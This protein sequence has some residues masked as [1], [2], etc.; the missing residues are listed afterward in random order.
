MILLDLAII[1]SFVVLT[2]TGYTAGLLREAIVLMAAVVGVALAGQAY[3][4]LAGDL[5]N[6]IDDEQ[7]ALLI[8]FL[9]LIGA[10]VLVGMI[11]SFVIKTT[12]TVF[13]LGSFDSLGGAFCG[14]AKALV[15]IEAVLIAFVTF[16]ALGMKDAI[17]DSVFGSLLLEQLP[18]LKA[19]LPAA[20]DA[21]IDSL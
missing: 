18:L 21:A 5:N 4:N 13:D 6:F 20:F 3:D 15:L 7:D 12:L 11:I 14:A 16:P 19:I 17:D 1:A 9:S 8:A 10:V 2:Y